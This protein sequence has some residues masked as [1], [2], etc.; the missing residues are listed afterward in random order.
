[1]EGTSV[2]TVQNDVSKREAAGRQRGKRLTFGTGMLTFRDPLLSGE[3]CHSN[4]IIIAM[5]Q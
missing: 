4:S 5:H 2:R 1:M 3:L